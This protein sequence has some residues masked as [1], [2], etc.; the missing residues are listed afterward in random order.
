MRWC[1]RRC[2]LLT[3]CAL[4]LGTPAR[5]DL[6]SYVNAPDDSFAWAE[7]GRQPTGCTNLK[8]TSQ[9][10]QGLPWQHTLSIFKP[11]QPKYPDLCVLLI[12]GGR[13]GGQQEMSLGMMLANSLGVSFAVLWDIPNQPLF[14]GLK[15]DALI[16]YT[17][18]QALDTGDM[19]WPLL[20]PMTKS[21]VRAMDALQAWSEQQGAK[22]ERFLTTG[23]SKRGWTTWFTA[24]ADSRV[25]A[26]MPM[27]YD[28]LNLAAQMR[29][30]LELWGKY[31]PQ[32]DDYTK[33]GLQDKLISAEGLS[34]AAAVDPYTYRDRINVPKLIINGT[35][36]AYWTLD[37]LNLYRAQ[38]SGPTYQIYVPNSGHGL[39]DIPRVLSAAQGFIRLIATQ[40]PLPQFTWLHTVEDGQAVLRILAPTATKATLWSAVAATAE[41]GGSQ[42]TSSEMTKAGE[43]WL[44]EVPIP[45]GQNVT[46]YG[47]VTLPSGTGSMPLSTTLAIEK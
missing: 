25:C 15:E 22:Y 43:A 11:A 1:S 14:N 21:A 47:E 27:V 3:L 45:E 18:V 5:A 24:A 39:E 8:M 31:S 2:G 23:A 46:V 6:L 9:T 10:W 28:N 7:I 13:Y 42:W 37:S 19:S 35:N 30:Q 40:A 20:Y 34:F 26:I 4:W 17:F 29:H 41:F 36:D 44:G 33:L 12:T 32:I 38:L 16:A